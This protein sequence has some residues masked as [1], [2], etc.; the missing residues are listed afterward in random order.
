[1]QELGDVRRR[2]STAEKRALEPPPRV[3]PPVSLAEVKSFAEEAAEEA[4]SAMGERVGLSKS[5]LRKYELR[6]PGPHRSS[7]SSAWSVRA[8]SLAPN[9]C[10]ACWRGIQL[11]QER[12]KRHSATCCRSYNDEQ[13]QHLRTLGFFGHTVPL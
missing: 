7:N 1:M 8:Y 12:N 3:A 4:A 5:R 2:Q 11:E 9:D 13:V 10:N 6:R